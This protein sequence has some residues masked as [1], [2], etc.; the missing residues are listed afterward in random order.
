MKFIKKLR[1]DLKEYLFELFEINKVF[2][3]LDDIH[4]KLKDINDDLKDI[5]CS[6]I[7]D[8]DSNDFV[9]SFDYERDISYIESD[10]SELQDYDLYYISKTL[11]GLCE[12]VDNLQDE[13]TAYR[14]EQA[15]LE[16]AM[17]ALCMTLGKSEILKILEEDI[18]E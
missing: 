1:Y 18:D 10:I 6:E 16:R 9:S 15:K 13:V 3:Q 5:Q 2:N 7:L 4:L 12:T 8:F 11:D 14:I 17:K